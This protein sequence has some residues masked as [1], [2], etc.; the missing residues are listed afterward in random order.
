MSNLTY[1][2]LFQNKIVTMA[3]APPN[4]L[5]TTIC[6]NVLSLTA[7]QRDAIVNNGW[8]HLS[9]FQGF[10]FDRTQTWAMESNRLL[11]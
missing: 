10:N 4:N 11:A 7:S 8:A 3:A 2:F 5:V 1:Y 9:D 6:D